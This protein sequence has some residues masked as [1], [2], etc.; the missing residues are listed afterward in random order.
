MEHRVL[1]LEFFRMVLLGELHLQVLL[2]AD[3]HT[4]HLLFK[5][6]DKGMAADLQHLLFGGAAG[7]SHAV[8]C[9]GV[10]QIH[11]VAVLHRAVFHVNGAAGLVLVLA[12]TGVDH[13][14]GQLLLFRFNGQSLVVAQLYIGA[15]KHFQMELQVFACADL[16]QINLGPVHGMKVI[17]LHSRFIHVRE[18]HFKRIIIEN[19]FAVHPLDQAPGS[20]AFAEAGNIDPS[21]QLQICF[22]HRFVELFSG[23]SECQ[24]R[25]VS[26]NL[27]IGMAHEYLSS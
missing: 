11:G 2:L 9:A 16:I 23:N 24:F 1:A 19:A 15:Y 26:G 5:A 6:G 3:V 13:L 14:V 20:F 25:F 10:V 4:D 8:H 21:A 18:N 22:L 27:L 17:F 7:K 12:D